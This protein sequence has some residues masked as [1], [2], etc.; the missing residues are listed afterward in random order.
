D[1]AARDAEH[2]DR[3]KARRC[4]RMQRPAQKSLAE[5]DRNGEPGRMALR[6]CD[7]QPM[8]ANDCVRE[9]VETTLRIGAIEQNTEPGRNLIRAQEILA[10]VPDDWHPWRSAGEDQ[11]ASHGRHGRP[12]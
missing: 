7:E 4:E 12:P 10:L 11:P 3:P 2:R 6:P 9:S 8:L 5:G 1:T